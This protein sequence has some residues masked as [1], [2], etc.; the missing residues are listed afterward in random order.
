MEAPADTA[1]GLPD[2]EVVIQEVVTI[3]RVIKPI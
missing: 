2:I 1:A 3:L